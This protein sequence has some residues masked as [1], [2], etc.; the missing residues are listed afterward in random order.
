MQQT[1]TSEHPLRT[2]I[3]WIACAFVIGVAVACVCMFLMVSALGSFLTAAQEGPTLVDVHGEFVDQNIDAGYEDPVVLADDPLL[4]TR[5][6]VLGHNVN[7]HSA[8]DVVTRLIYLNAVDSEAPID[9]YLTTLGGWSDNAFTIIDT[10]QMIDAPVN[11]Y[12]VGACYSSGAMILT[13]GTGRRYATPNT[14]IMLHANCV[15]DEEEY[16]MDS[17]DTQRYHRLWREHSK[18]PED[19]YPMIY[20]LEYYFPAEKALEYDVIDE[21]L[22]P[23]QSEQEVSQP[24]EAVAEPVG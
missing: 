11:T 20:D 2:P 9:L 22:L 3:I 12:A 18:V 1:D 23:K 17:L 5:K 7:A 8:K 4:A 15:D 21:I 10:M 14:V 19:W 6:I 24:S 13:A 16:S